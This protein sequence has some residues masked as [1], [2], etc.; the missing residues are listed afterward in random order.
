MK[1]KF[2]EGK[3]G[4]IFDPRFFNICPEC[5]K[6]PTQEGEVF[7]CNEHGK[8]IPE[9]R[10]LINLVIDDGSETIRAVLFHENI[11]KLGLDVDNLENAEILSNGKQALLGKEMI[12]TGMVK[13]NSYFNNLEFSVNDV[14]AVDVNRL[15]EK[16]E[17]K[18]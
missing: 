1:Q 8:I 6:K 18:G 12:F 7:S 5:K 17:G 16:L 2:I 9:R 10:A 3:R 13:R 11:A 14:V 15:I 4:Q